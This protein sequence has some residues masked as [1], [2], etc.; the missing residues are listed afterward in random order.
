MIWLKMISY[1]EKNK[2]LIETITGE[3]LCYKNIDT[4]LDINFE[5]IQIK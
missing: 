5:L 2:D 4:V 1:L 3:T